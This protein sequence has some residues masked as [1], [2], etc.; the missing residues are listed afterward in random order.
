ME[1]LSPFEAVTVDS[2]SQSPTHM[3]I[4]FVRVRAL[5]CLRTAQQCSIPDLQFKVFPPSFC[6]L[7]LQHLGP[8]ERTGEAQL[9]YKL[10]HQL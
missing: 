6:A 7:M 5:A 9:E 4:R 10:V 8:G 3:G 2:I 1:L